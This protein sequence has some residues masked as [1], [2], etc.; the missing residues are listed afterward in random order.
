MRIE[1]NEGKGL[2]NTLIEKKNKIFLIYTEIQM[3]T[4]AKSYVKE[5]L[6]N[7]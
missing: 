5:G 6:P 1:I 4:V 3:G 2:Q 7:I